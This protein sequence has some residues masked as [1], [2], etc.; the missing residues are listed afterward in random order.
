MYLVIT[1][2]LDFLHLSS[3]CFA[4]NKINVIKDQDVVIM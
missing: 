2:W 3:V 4:S 1:M